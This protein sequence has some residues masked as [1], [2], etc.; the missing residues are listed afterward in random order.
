MPSPSPSL[1][2]PYPIPH[3]HPS[4]RSLSPPSSLLPRHYPSLS[5]IHTYST[6]C[7][8]NGR[9]GGS[10]VRVCACSPSPPPSSSSISL[11]PSSS[12]SLPSPP[13][14]P[15]HSPSPPPSPSS[16]SPSPPLS[17]LSSLPFTF[18]FA[19]IECSDSV[20]ICAVIGCVPATQRAGL[21]ASRPI[22]DPDWPLLGSQRGTTFIFLT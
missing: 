4:P 11:S 7:C 14:S 16:P 3:H 20:A 17:P 19:T 2:L 13:P 12:S 5:P 22:N 21:A 6:V 10:G 18:T 8:A 9:C 15:S 1:P